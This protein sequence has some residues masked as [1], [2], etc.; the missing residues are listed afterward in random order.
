MKIEFGGALKW[1]NMNK[2]QIS[3]SLQPV[4]VDPPRFFLNLSKDCHPIAKKSRRYCGK[5]QL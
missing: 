2:I 1:F 4:A 3:C 5:A